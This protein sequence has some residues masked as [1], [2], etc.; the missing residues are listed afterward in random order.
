MPGHSPRCPACVGQR[1]GGQESRDGAGH[2]WPALGREKGQTA[3]EGWLASECRGGGPAG[4]PLGAGDLSAATSPASQ[5][6]LGSV[7]KYVLISE[8]GPV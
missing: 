8:T 3:R 1:Q 2:A 5:A 7:L 4:C 6:A